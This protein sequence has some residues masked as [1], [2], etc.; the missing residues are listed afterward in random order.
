MWMRKVI[1]IIC[2]IGVIVLNA[3]YY[4]YQFFL[5]LA[6]AVLVPL[7]SFIWY[8]LSKTGLRI[9]ANVKAKNVDIGGDVELCVRTQSKYNA[10][11]PWNTLDVTA[12]Y[13]N[14]ITDNAGSITVLNKEKNLIFKPEHCGVMRINCERFEVRDGLQ[15]F[16]TKYDCDITRK[17]FVFPKVLRAKSHAEGFINEDMQYRFS[18]MEPDNTEVF[19]LRKYENGD[20]L[21]KIHWKLSLLTEDYIVKQYGEQEDESVNIIVDLSKYAA[22][23]FM[24]NL[25]KIY[26]AAYSF[27]IFFCERGAKARFIAW[28]SERKQIQK[29]DFTTFEELKY[30]MQKLMSIR[31][32][33]DNIDILAGLENEEL[34][35]E[36]TIIISQVPLN[37]ENQNVVN[38]AKED[39]QE[40]LDCMN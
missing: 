24:E 19:D 7:M 16:S 14:N 22:K 3:L 35:G 9:S 2:L 6:V 20:S 33:N 10:A 5:M 28:N 12:D 32:G 21:K 27:G 39:I 17:V 4:N 23:D 1:Y 30:A 26:Q 13:L 11:L 34:F 31:C 29:E 8:F 37:I 15:I 36:N 25:D 40:I 38:V 18:Y